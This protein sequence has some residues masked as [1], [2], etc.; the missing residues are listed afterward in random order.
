[1]IERGSGRAMVMDFGIS[2]REGVP[3]LTA[4]GQL[5]GSVHYISP[6]RA[7]GEVASPAS[8]LYALGVTGYYMLTGLLPIDGPSPAAILVGHLMKTPAL[9]S[10]VRDD[11]PS[12]LSH[13]IM[14]C[15]AKRAADRFPTAE[16]FAEEMQRVIGAPIEIPPFLRSWIARG[17]MLRWVVLLW[18]LPVVIMPNDELLKMFGAA[19]PSNLATLVGLRLVAML[20]GLPATILV[21]FVIRARD[22]RRALRGGYSIDDLRYALAAWDRQR[23]EEDT[24]AKSRPSLLRR[25]TRALGVVVA[26]A[27]TIV[28]LK[29]LMESS[30]TA[31]VPTVVATNALIGALLGIAYLAHLLKAD[32]SLRFLRR[33]FWGSAAGATMLRLVGGRQRTK[34]RKPGATD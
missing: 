16:A 22:A 1:M 24:I 30:A 26:V 13:A 4:V 2:Q 23:R 5:V 14:R 6:E 34:S 29:L 20:I 18:V 15:L 3:A 9:I 19:A 12:S 11:I 10:A 21:C 31:R 7:E 27:V 25:A 8:D 28:S 17:E 33:L 32:S